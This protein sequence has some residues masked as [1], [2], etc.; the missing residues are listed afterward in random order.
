MCALS[1]D[2]EIIRR[3]LISPS[4]GGDRAKRRWARTTEEGLPLFFQVAHEFLDEVRRDGATKQ[5]LIIARGDR[6]PLYI[7]D[8]NNDAGGL[9]RQVCGQ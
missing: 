9:Y 8:A 6:R 4:L 3:L 5:P 7:H 2:S 1:W